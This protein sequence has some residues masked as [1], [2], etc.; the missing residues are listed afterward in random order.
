MTD[1]YVV[2]VPSSAPGG[3]EA[4]AS[5][6]FGHCDIFTIVT[7][8]DGKVEKVALQPNIPHEQGGCLAP[9]AMLAQISVNTLIAGGMGVRPLMGFNSAGIEV[10]HNNG[11]NRVDGI[12]SAFIKGQLPKFSQDNA[13]G[14][15][16]DQGGCGGH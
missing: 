9:V 13:C 12:I 4:E 1:K 8:A 6:H 11:I 10:Y 16:G 7:I 5:G 2:A 15:S 14:G 3:F